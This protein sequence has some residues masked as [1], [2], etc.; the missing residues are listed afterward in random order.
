MHK[1][2]NAGEGKRETGRGN[3]SRIMDG[4]QEVEE[5]RRLCRKQTEGVY[6]K[7]VEDKFSHMDALLKGETSTIKGAGDGL[8]TRGKRRLMK[9]RNRRSVWRTHHRGVGRAIHPRDIERGEEEYM[10]G[11][12]T[13]P[14]KI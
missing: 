14:R 9:R 12:P 7:E 1:E 4:T 8:H 5:L 11:C 6:P 10:G 2:T 3:G 13:K